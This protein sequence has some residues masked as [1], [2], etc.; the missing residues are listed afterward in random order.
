MGWQ[1]VGKN[2]KSKSLLSWLPDKEK[3][4]EIFCGSPTISGLVGEALGR[5]L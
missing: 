2:W 5:H 1:H 3:T 4:D